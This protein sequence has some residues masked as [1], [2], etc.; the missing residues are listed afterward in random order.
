MEKYGVDRE[1]FDLLEEKEG[2]EVVKL[3]EE[4]N[5]AIK[6]LNELDECKHKEES[7]DT[8]GNSDS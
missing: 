1:N 5:P 2:E 8:D 7:D 3:A 6:V 4:N